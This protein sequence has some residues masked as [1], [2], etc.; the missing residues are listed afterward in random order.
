M[1]FYL[2]I[3]VPTLCHPPYIEYINYKF[4][5]VNARLLYI[6]Q[7]HVVRYSNNRKSDQNAH[8][9]EY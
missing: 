8:M 7:V 9:N 2:D 6:I 5:Q 4:T 1:L 3:Q